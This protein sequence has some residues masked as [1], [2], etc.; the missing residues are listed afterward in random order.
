[1]GY[2]DGFYTADNIIGYTGRLHGHPS[3]YF[4][5]L[6]NFGYG[7]ITMAHG[8]PTNVGR[9]EYQED[10]NYLIEN[11]DINEINY[12]VGEYTD[13]DHLL[14]TGQACVE[15]ATGQGG[16]QDSFHTSRNMLVPVRPSHFF[17]NAAVQTVA[18]AVCA[19]AIR[20]FPNL[21]SRYS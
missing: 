13:H 1:M 16:T 9:E 18:L 17:P 4:F 21:K 2:R 10:Q 19:V 15:W 6:A 7:H 8:D 12:P 3:V 14:A 5:D 11:T 20:E